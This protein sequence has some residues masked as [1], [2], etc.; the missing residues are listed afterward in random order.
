MPE[1]IFTATF[2]QF[3]YVKDT[4]HYGDCIFEE[5]HKKEDIIEFLSL[6]QGFIKR[7]EDESNLRS[8]STITHLKENN[9]ITVY[10]YVY[11]QMIKKDKS[12]VTIYWNP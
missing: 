6:V 12:Y 8:H 4:R 10:Q 5:V 7:V 11:D 1:G 3:N 2:K 9:T